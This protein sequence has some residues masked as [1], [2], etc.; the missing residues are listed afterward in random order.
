[1][2]PQEIGALGI[3]VLIVLTLLRVPLGAA[4]GLVGLVGYAAIDGWDR[5]FIVFGNTPYSGLTNN[6]AREKVDEGIQAISLIA[7]LIL[8]EN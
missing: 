7:P 3:L 5:A 1:M 4:M 6:Q 8:C 2:S